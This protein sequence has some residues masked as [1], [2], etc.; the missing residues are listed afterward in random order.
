MA[1]AGRRPDAVRQG[2]ALASADRTRRSCSPDAHRHHGVT[3]TGGD[4]APRAGAGRHRDRHA[5]PAGGRA[6]GPRERPRR[7]RRGAA[8]RGDQRGRLHG[9]RQGRKRGGSRDAGQRRR[10]GPRR[11]GRG[12]SRRAAAAPLDRLRVRRD[13]RPPLSRG[14]SDRP[15]WRLRPL[16]AHRRTSGLGALAEQR[17]PA[18]RLGLQ[19]VRREFRPHHA[20][21]E[22]D[23]RRGR[24]GR[25]P[26][27]AIRRRRSTSPTRCSR[28]PGA[29]AGTIRPG[30]AA[31]S[32]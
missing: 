7:G 28:S 32:T 11:R 13:A 21:A 19:P 10:R 5:E 26:A 29:S 4:L 17:R 30:C 15:D 20:A 18:H 23:A 8:G 24:R 31:C 14:R 6:R 2:Q 1:A 3:G 22:R 9:G 27:S 25:R 12:Q 16:E